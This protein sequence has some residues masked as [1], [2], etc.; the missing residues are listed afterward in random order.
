MKHSKTTVVLFALLV[1]VF[2]F[3]VHIHRTGK[4]ASP[5]PA[6][7]VEQL[8]SAHFGAQFHENSGWS[9]TSGKPSGRTDGLHPWAVRIYRWNE[10]KLKSFGLSGP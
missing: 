7:A 8:S 6:V 2:T 9:G 3:V 1:L 5:N 4:V 10:K